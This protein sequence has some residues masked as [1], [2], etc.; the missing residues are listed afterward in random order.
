VRERGL[1]GGARG[2]KKEKDLSR[3]GIECERHVYREKNTQKTTDR[4][5]IAPTQRDTAYTR[6]LHPPSMH[7]DG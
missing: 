1:R 6:Y 7:I 3:R 5:E 4:Y 2:W